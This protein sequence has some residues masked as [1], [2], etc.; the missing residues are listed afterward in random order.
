MKTNITESD[1]TQFSGSE[2]WYRHGMNRNLIYTDGVQWL[3]E[4]AGAYWLVDEVAI[5]NMLNAKVRSQEFQVW[6]LKV[7]GN[8]ATLRC[9]DGNGNKVISKRIPFTDFPL[10]KVTLWC[11]GGVIMLPS[12]Y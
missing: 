4:N 3:A 5:Y 8:G 7:K 2:N 9:E 12:E 1:L 11:A 10:P 6:T